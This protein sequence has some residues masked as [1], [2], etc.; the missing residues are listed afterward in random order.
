MLIF[1]LFYK[2]FI[3]QT[4]RFVNK[5]MFQVVNPLTAFNYLI[6]LWK[7]QLLKEVA[8]YPI[9]LLILKTFF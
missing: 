1:L 8:F 2:H 9:L 4:I 6:Q 3:F 5:K 7:W